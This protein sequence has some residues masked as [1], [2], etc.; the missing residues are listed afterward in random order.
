MIY[1]YTIKQK[2]FQVHYEQINA[3]YALFFT[4]TA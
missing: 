3:K 1:Y 4:I 2:I